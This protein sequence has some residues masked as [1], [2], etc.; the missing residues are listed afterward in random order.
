MSVISVIGGTGY[1][2]RAIVAEAARRGHEVRSFSRRAPE[3]R[4][5]GVVYETGSV[6][7]E[8]VRA[9]ALEQ[10]DIVVIAFSPRGDMIDVLRPLV[11]TIAEEA[12]ERG[13]RL[14]VVGGAGSLLVAPDGPR[15]VDTPEF[16]DFVRPESLTMA[17][18]IDDL[19]ISPSELDWF[20]LCPAAGFGAQAPGEAR[21]VYRIG[22]DVLVTDDHGISD[23]SGADFALAFV[24]EIEH[25]A[26]HRKRFTVAY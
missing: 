1:A 26:H 15:L 20:V 9:D 16:P 22:G 6:V 17:A 21:G 23:I 10:V 5:P 7:D 11:N 3:N 2:G 14:G 12:A 4:V 24:D 13:V 18:V 19:K 25:P 8:D